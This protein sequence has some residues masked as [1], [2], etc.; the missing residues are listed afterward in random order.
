MLVAVN[1]FV[2]R[3]VK[4]SGKT[5]AKTLSFDQIAN[6]AS[7]QMQNKIYRDGYRDGVRIVIVDDSIKSDFICPFVKLNS[8]IKLISKLVCRR[9]GEESL[10]TN[11]SN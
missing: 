4:N 11:K 7:S 10:Y 1:D 5:Y 8:N 9:E 2:K 3:Q 6:H